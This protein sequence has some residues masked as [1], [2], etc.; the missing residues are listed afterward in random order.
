[1]QL[2]NPEYLWRIACQLKVLDDDFGDGLVF[3][4]VEQN[5][6]LLDKRLLEKLAV[7]PLAI[8]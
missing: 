4:L 5:V 7:L 1:M 6:Q 3:V 2:S 8:C